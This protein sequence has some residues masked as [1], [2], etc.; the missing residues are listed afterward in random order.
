MKPTPQL[1]CS[2]EGSYSP[3]AGGIAELIAS[4]LLEQVPCGGVSVVAAGPHPRP[5]PGGWPGP[6]C[7]D[8]SV[9]LDHKGTGYPPRAGPLAKARPA[10]VFPAS[11]RSGGR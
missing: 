9:G 10:G 8:P 6:D 4:I 3:W 5:G 11:M 1:S 7:G 2:L